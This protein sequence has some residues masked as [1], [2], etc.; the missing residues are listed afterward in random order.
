MVYASLDS[1]SA[2]VIVGGSSGALQVIDLAENE[3]VYVESGA[4][5]VSSEV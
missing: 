3:V 5:L 2:Y 4:D 1:E